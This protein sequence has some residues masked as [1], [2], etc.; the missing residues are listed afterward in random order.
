MS[1][2]IMTNL[3]LITNKKVFR[4]DDKFKTQNKQKIWITQKEEK[5]VF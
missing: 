3:S 2:C 5:L 1:H 4:E